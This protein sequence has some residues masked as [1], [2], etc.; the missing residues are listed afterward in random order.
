MNLPADLLYTQG[1]SGRGDRSK[2]VKNLGKELR[3]VRRRV[4]PFNQ[5]THQPAANSFQLGDLVLIYQQQ[6]EK[7]HRL[8]PR[9]RGPFKVTEIINSFQVT[10]EDQGKRKITLISNCKK[11]YDQLVDVGEATP[12]IDVMPEVKKWAV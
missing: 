3:E 11:Y 2:Y 10:Y 9:W 12:P 8:S 4:T 6:M 5:A 7:T 1:D